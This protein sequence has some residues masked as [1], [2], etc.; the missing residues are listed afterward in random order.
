MVKL[1]LLAFIGC[2]LTLLINLPLKSLFKTKRPRMDKYQEMEYGFPS[3]HTHVAFTIVTI[4]S[5]Y[6][7]LLFIPSF[8]FATFVGISR[9]M[10]KSHNFI[11]VIFGSIFGVLTGIAILLI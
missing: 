5:F 1:T 11:D 7:R 2:I 8:G 3:F 10:T 4:Y 9:L 6:F